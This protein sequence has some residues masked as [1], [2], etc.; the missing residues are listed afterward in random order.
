MYQIISTHIINY[1]PQIGRG[2]ACR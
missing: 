1:W 2:S